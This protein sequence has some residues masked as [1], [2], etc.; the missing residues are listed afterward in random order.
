MLT[1]QTENSKFDLLHEIHKEGT[2]HLLFPSLQ[3]GLAILNL[4]QKVRTGV[5]PGGR[6]SESD[7]YNALEGSRL[8]I[9]QEEYDR[10]PQQKFNSMISDLQVY[11]LRYNI[12]EQVYT[13]KEYAESF[14]QHAEETLKANFNPTQI[15]HICNGLRS[16]LDECQD[17][18]QVKTWMDTYFDAFKPRMRS[19]VDRLE[20]Q[21]DNSV[22]EIRATAQLSDVSIMEILKAIDQKLD[23]LRT[24]NEELRSAFREMKTI[25]LMLELHLPNATEHDIASGIAEVRQFF[26]EV[27]YTLNVIDKRLD[28]IQ[29][30]LRQFFGMLNKP[31]FHIRMEKFLKL[32]LS[33]S[34][35][36]DQ[37]EVKFPMG[38]PIFRF[39]QQTSNFTIFERREDLFPAKPK[40]R[41]K[42]TENPAEVAKGLAVARNQLMI[43][44]KVDLHLEEILSAASQGEILFSGYFFNIVDQEAGSVE[45]ALNVAYALIRKAGQDRQLH[46]QVD[47]KKIKHPQL[48]IALWEM[49]INYKH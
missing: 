43:Y 5:F 42:P 49:K 25:N 24:Q 34:T 40:Q 30:K 15:E 23:K 26:P 19:Q 9:S 4:Y 17:Q 6:F 47:R 41:V 1:E 28:R 27:K 33:A 35:L 38:I 12:D 8:M 2:Y 14:C 44:S 39:H 16:K 7:I 20:R 3:Q 18:Y 32:L 37:K 11:F 13:L 48:K 29:P 45:L 22:Q 31:S 21:I 10:L 36:S 46:I